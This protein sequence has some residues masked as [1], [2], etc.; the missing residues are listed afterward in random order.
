MVN[1]LGTNNAPVSAKGME[2]ALAV[3]GANIHIYG[4]KDSRP[5]RKMG[6]ITALAPGGTAADALKIAQE[7]AGYLVF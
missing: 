7:A 5:G 4:K 6:H 3:P 1:L 2:K